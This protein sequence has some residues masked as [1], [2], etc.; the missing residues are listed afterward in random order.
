MRANHQDKYGGPGTFKTGKAVLVALILLE[1]VGLILVLN[2]CYG[3]HARNRPITDSGRVEGDVEH[4]HVTSLKRTAAE[5]EQA[6]EPIQ[7]KWGKLFQQSPCAIE[8]YEGLEGKYFAEEQYAQALRMDGKI[9]ELLGHERNY[10]W[11]TYLAGLAHDEVYLQVLS[12][13]SEV[14]SDP[15][16][17]TWVEANL[18]WARGDFACVCSVAKRGTE[19]SGLKTRY[20]MMFGL[21]HSRALFQQGKFSEAFATWC[22]TPGDKD[23]LKENFTFLLHMLIESLQMARAAKDYDAALQPADS[24]KRYL[25][26]VVQDVSWKPHMQVVKDFFREY[27]RQPRPDTAPWRSS[28]DAL[29]D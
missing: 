3:R 28:G 4:W 16:Y 13:R 10:I 22:G 26:V 25:T 5:A 14:L 17:R 7:E 18:A 24:L 11:T 8:A 15:E 6:L 21:L 27:S 2:V 20:A 23:Y 9:R 1:I 12:R 29:L 19:I